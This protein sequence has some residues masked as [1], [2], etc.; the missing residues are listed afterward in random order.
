MV[1]SEI[2]KLLGTQWK[3]LTDED[4]RPFI[5]ERLRE[6][7]MNYYK[8]QAEEKEDGV[9]SQCYRHRNRSPVRS[10]SHGETPQ[11]RQSQAA[12]ERLY[13]LVSQDEKED[14]RRKSKDAQLGD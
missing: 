14:S 10:S 12:Y 2:S 13:G 1:D 9:T 5:D 4:K 6:A 7:H 8:V 11:R 3:A